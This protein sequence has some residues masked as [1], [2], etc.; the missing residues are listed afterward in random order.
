M[1]Q[2]DRKRKHPPFFNNS[3]HEQLAANA[4]RQPRPHPVGRQ[5]VRMNKTLRQKAT[6]AYTKT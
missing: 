2:T 6:G 4:V 1:S 5:K 3:S